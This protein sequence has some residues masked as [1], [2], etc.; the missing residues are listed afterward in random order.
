MTEQSKKYLKTSITLGIIA[1]SS[2]LLISLSNLVTRN[3]IAENE[4]AKINSSI[5]EIYG[6]S[7]I[8]KEDGDYSKESFKYVNHYYTIVDNNDNPLGLAFR[9]AGS[10][11]YGKISLI[12][13]FDNPDY[14]FKG[15]YVITDE[16]TYASTLED[17]YIDPVNDGERVIDDVSCGATYGAKLV[18]DMIKEAK[19]AA[20]SWGE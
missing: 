2:A 1:A 19:D 10:N 7:A 14:N 16:Q 8:V 15:M 9:T 20:D 17:K 6:D 3:R 11:S 4:V 5:K 13:G 12:V 18:R